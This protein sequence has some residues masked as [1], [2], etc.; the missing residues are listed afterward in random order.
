MEEMA[1]DYS[2]VTVQETDGG[3]TE[4]CAWEE[5]ATSM[6]A[7]TTATQGFLRGSSVINGR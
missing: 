5:K 3:E 1:Q 2:E 4:D 7:T 6:V